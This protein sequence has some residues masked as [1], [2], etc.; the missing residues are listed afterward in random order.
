MRHRLAEWLMRG[1]VHD[2]VLAGHSVTVSEVRASRDLKHATAYVSLLGSETVPTEVLD[3]LNRS[4]GS[5]GGRLARA[6]HLKY[7]PRVRFEVDDRYAEAARIDALLR[8]ARS[9]DGDDA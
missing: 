4:A 7:A 1:E 2:P 9:G 3:A 6:L 8:A 5:L